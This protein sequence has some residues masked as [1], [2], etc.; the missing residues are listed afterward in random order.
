MD[1]FPGNKDLHSLDAEAPHKEEDQ[2]AANSRAEDAEHGA[3]HG[4]ESVSG[5]D[6]Q[7]FAGDDGHKDL[8][9]HHPQEG[10]PSPDAV[11]VH[12]Q[13]ELLRF[14]DKGQKRLSYKPE[15]RQRQ[16]QEQGNPGGRDEFLCLSVIIRNICI[17]TASSSKT[18]RISFVRPHCTGKS[19][20]NK[21][22][23]VL[24]FH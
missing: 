22:G 1:L 19:L 20:K 18:L 15:D 16:Q 12:P 23:K 9:E 10:Q 13:A 14:G 8:Q 7:G 21:Y 6:L 17:R 11:A 3:L 2:R 4:A 5:A 24:S